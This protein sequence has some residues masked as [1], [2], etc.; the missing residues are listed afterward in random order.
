[1]VNNEQTSELKL[2]T[3]QHYLDSR[4]D[5]EDYLNNFVDEDV[6][7]FYRR[8]TASCLPAKLDRIA[9]LLIELL[10]KQSK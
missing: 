6:M 1:M 8:A 7:K 3:I 5:P 9:D 10:E 4:M 2:L